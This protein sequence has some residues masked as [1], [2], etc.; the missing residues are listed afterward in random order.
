MRKVVFPHTNGDVIEPLHTIEVVC[1]YCG[2]D[3]D[4]A[5]LAAATCSD[6]GE[7]LELKQSVSITVTTLPPI[8]GQTL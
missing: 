3:L 8:F 5:E 2:F 1:G 7:P 6:C 4:E